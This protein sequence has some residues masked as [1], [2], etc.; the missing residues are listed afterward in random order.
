LT[1]TDY[2]FLSRPIKSFLVDLSKNILVDIIIYA[3]FSVIILVSIY[4]DVFSQCQ[5]KCSPSKTFENFKWNDIISGSSH[6][7][8]KLQGNQDYGT[9]L[10]FFYKYI[11]ERGKV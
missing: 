10:R 3:F 4:Q 5:L 1:D 8:S 11:D 7:R 6:G 9:W 2:D